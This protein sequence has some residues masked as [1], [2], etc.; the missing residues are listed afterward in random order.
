MIALLA[1]AAFAATLTPAEVLSRA[2]AAVGS[3]P[4][5]NYRIVTRYV[6][7]DGDGSSEEL[8]AGSDYEVTYHEGPVST[9]EGLLHGKTW[10]QNA[11]GLVVV[12]DNT[13][14]SDS[15]DDVHSAQDSFGTPSV[16]QQDSTGIVLEFH[17]KR[18][19]TE[20]RYYDP[21]S[22][23]LQRIDV[24]G[25][26]GTQSLMFGDYRR[27]FGKME[28]FHEE[29]R[30]FYQEDGWTSDVTSFTQPAAAPQLAIP[31]SRSVFDL[32]TRTAVDI[33]ANFTLD[34]VIVR[35]N[36]AGRGLDFELD[37]GSSITILDADVARQLGLSTYNRRVSYDLVKVS[38][39]QAMIGDFGI[40]D[41][42]ATN[43]VVDTVPFNEL[44]GQQRVVG[45]LGADFFASSRIAIDFGKR[46]IEMLAP[47]NPLPGAGWTKLPIDVS[48][49][50]PLTDATLDG[51]KGS[52]VV[53][54]GAFQTILFPHYVS[55]FKLHGDR[56]LRG[57]MSGVS[58]TPL[59]YTAYTVPRMDLG[60]LSYADIPVDAMDSGD[61]DFDFGDG[62][63]GYNFWQNF[64]M[65]FDYADRTLYIKPEV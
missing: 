11:N 39:A 12:G 50:V 35:V 15:S 61:P 45:L 31:Q 49:L 25:S 56:R 5:G 18:G 52:F 22:F 38:T 54:L 63:L 16:V 19:L 20:R 43:F 42:H 37:S 62:L 29:F 26:T 48:Q 27:V 4:S 10:T 33:P 47:S 40:G 7:A 46:T 30:S 21:V 65:L 60:D 51:V 53:D 64:A 9:A 34:R 57:L 8:I 17:S 23:L 55:R 3:S 13:T 2:S 59:K 41:V 14:A 28:P 58:G 36:V 6:F 32:G 24:T 1:A 44:V